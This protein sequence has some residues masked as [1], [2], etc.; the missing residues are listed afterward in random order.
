MVAEP[1][2]KHDSDYGGFQGHWNEGDLVRHATTE[3]RGK[4]TVSFT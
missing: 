2:C 4:L 1:V 3:F